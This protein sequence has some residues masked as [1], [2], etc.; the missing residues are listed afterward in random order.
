MLNDTKYKNTYMNIEF[1]VTR[2]FLVRPNFST[3]Q[4]LQQSSLLFVYRQGQFGKSICHERVTKSEFKVT[5]HICF[6]LDFIRF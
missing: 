3:C 6:T 4:I 2:K 1:N 5:Y